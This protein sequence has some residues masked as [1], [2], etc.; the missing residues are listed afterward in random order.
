VINA[1]FA[2]INSSDSLCKSMK[3]NILSQLK[4]VGAKPDSPTCTIDNS[5]ST[6]SFQI[7][8]DK[9]P[10]T[11]QFLNLV[12]GVEAAIGGSFKFPLANCLIDISG[13]L[14]VDMFTIPLM[15]NSSRRV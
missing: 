6:M 14:L 1:T 11:T 10:V 2:G 3:D 13:M 5:T 12:K 7:S 4:I 15:L 9:Q 8:I